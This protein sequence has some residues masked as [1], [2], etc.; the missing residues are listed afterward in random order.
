MNKSI[1]IMVNTI[2]DILID[3]NPSIYILGSVVLDD[4]QLGWSDIDILCLTEHSISSDQA[5]KLLH[6]RQEL[7][8]KYI[9]SPYFRAFEG[10]FISLEAFLNKQEDKVVYWGTTGERIAEHYEF[11]VFSMMN[12]MDY[13]RLLYGKDIRFLL[14]YPNVK[15]QF[16]AINDY[17]CIIR[18]YFDKPSRSLYAAGNLLDIARCL[19]TL[20]SG[21][22]ISKTNAGLW[23]LENNL[24]PDIKIMHR[25]LKIRKHPNNY[26]EDEKTLEWLETLGP[27]IM[28]F[29][30]VLEKNIRIKQVEGGF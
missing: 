28:E 20:Q 25:V 10:G 11:D 6:L 3:N 5:E 1:D 23:A 7:S 2:A 26:K 17:Y 13:G 9:N 15:A 4:F 27:N 24:V 14:N 19:Y 18:K 30:D 12:L 21:K 8:A 16:D 22:I 29:A